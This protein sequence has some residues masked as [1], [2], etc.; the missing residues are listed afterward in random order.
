MR[1]KRLLL[2]RYGL[3]DGEVEIEFSGSGIDLI[4]G[5]NE[6]GKSTIMDGI[7]SVLFGTK[8]EERGDL[9]PWSGSSGGQGILE[10]E[11]DNIMRIQREVDSQH[12]TVTANPEEAPLELFNDKASPQ[13]KK[14]LTHYLKIIG[15]KVGVRDR[16]LLES[17]TFVRQN[18]METELGEK[19][20]EIISGS[21]RGDYKKAID[22]LIGEADSLTADVPWARKKRQDKQLE[23]LE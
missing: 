5:D 3:F 16:D 18:Q 22:T 6:S 17:L 2:S 12:T 21:G 13:G 23:K 9:T 14:E 19:I 4:I 20:R 15:E 7:L 1:L 10:I 8:R 11:S